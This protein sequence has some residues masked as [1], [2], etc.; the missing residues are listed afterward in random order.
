MAFVKVFSA[1][2]IFVDFCCFFTFSSML[3]L[4]FAQSALLEF[5]EVFGRS[6]IVVQKDI[7]VVDKSVPQNNTQLAV[8]KFANLKLRGKTTVTSSEENHLRPKRK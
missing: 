3:S 1:W 5:M 6:D 8:D 7:T 2:L 4:R